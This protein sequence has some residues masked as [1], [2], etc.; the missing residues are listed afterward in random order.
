MCFSG[1]VII[2]IYGLPWLVLILAPL[3][4][5]YHWLQELYRL[6]SRELK[7]LSS[8]TLSPVYSHFNETLLGLP[9]I[10]SFRAVARSVN[11]SKVLMFSVKYMCVICQLSACVHNIMYFLQHLGVV[12]C[13]TLV[14]CFGNCKI[15][16]SSC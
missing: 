11:C 2:T 15:F 14:L 4:P 16:F 6:T 12:H 10:R 5:V 7:R 9:T 8:V 3:V 13:L 1:T